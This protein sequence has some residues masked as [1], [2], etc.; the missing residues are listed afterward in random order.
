MKT[1]LRITLASLLLSGCAANMAVQGQN[2]PDLNVVKR[3]ETRDDVER[4]LG[5]PTGAVRGEDGAMVQVYIV[6]ARTEPSVTRAAGHAAVDLFTFGLWEFVGGPVEAYKGR[7][8]R[9]LVEY[10]ENDSVVRM[11][12]DRRIDRDAPPGAAGAIK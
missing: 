9:V 6:E 11:S 7:K 8:Q 5:L 1:L 10:D 2:G 4:M 3:Q 12:A